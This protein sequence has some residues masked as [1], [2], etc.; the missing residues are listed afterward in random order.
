MNTDL[1][2]E[3][4]R[5]LD[6]F[7][8]RRRRLLLKRGACASA[9]AFLSAIALLA[10]VDYLTFLEDIARVALSLIAYTLVL[11]LAWLTSLRLM[12]RRPGRRE[13]ACL[14]ETC[15]PD[16]REYLL[17]AVEL[18]ESGEAVAWDSATYRQLLQEEVA[19]R[20]ASTDV[21]EQLPNS[22]IRWWPRLAAAATLLTVILLLLPGTHY[23]RLFAR[24]AIPG[25]NIS[26]L[27][28]T[29][30]Q[31]IQ[32]TPADTVVPQ[33]DV[34]S[35][36]A[37]LTGDEADHAHLESFV[38]GRAAGRIRMK[39]IAPRRFSAG[40]KIARKSVR[41]RVRAGDGMTRKY[42]IS[43]V[44][45]PRIT[46]F[47]KIITYPDY[48]GFPPERLV[49]SSGDLEVIEGAN[50]DLVL[51][52]DQRVGEAELRMTFGGRK[53]TIALKRMMLNKL[54]G[55][56]RVSASGTYRVHLVAAKTS[57]ENRF[58]PEYEIRTFP[59]LAPSVNITRP[60]RNLSAL[61]NQVLDMEIH[62]KD[63]LGLVEVFQMARVN[64]GH[65]RRLPVD[66]N[67]RGKEITIQHAW[68]M[69]AM[70]IR[71]GDQVTTKFMAKDLK[72][73]EGA[74]AL[75]TVT[76]V[77]PG[78]DKNRLEPLRRMKEIAETLADLHDAAVELRKTT[79]KAMAALRG[80]ETSSLKRRQ[81]VAR[82][83][84]ASEKVKEWTEAAGNQVKEAVKSAPGDE[85]A[86]EMTKFGR[87]LSK[88][89]R[90]GLEKP[91]EELELS[92]RTNSAKR[93]TQL[94]NQAS[95]AFKNTTSAS[96]KIARI[97]KQRLASE[98]ATVIVEDLKHL[99]AELDRTAAARKRAGDDSAAR[100]NLGRRQK[101]SLAHGGAV[102]KM[103]E[104]LSKMNCRGRQ[105]AVK[106]ARKE[107]N[108]TR[109]ASEKALLSAD[110]PAN[111]QYRRS[112]ESALAN[113]REVARELEKAAANGRTEL[114]RMIGD[115]SSDLDR[116]VSDI[117]KATEATRSQTPDSQET[118]ASVSAMQCHVKAR[119][120]KDRAD[121]EELR[122]DADGEF[123]NDITKAAEALE[124]LGAAQAGPDEQE[125]QQ[126]ELGRIS[127]AFKDLEIGHEFLEAAAMV[128]D[129]A[130][131]E[132]WA[133]PEPGADLS[134]ARD[135]ARADKALKSVVGRMKSAGIPREIQKQMEQVQE[136]SST[137]D[138]RKEMTGRG[139][140]A[141]DRVC[142][143]DQ[144]ADVSLE[145]DT[146]KNALAPRM[147]KAR[148][149][150]GRLRPAFAGRLRQ[151]AE[152]ARFLLDK[153]DSL[154]TGAREKS[155]RAVREGARGLLDEQE[156]LNEKLDDLRSALRRDANAQDLS[157]R[158]G[159]E[160]ARDADDAQALLR[161]P[162]PR[163]EDH[164]RQ[165]VGSLRKPVRLDAIK[166]ARKQQEE[167]AVIL[168]QLAVHFANLAADKPRETRAVLRR[169]ENR[170]G[171]G[172]KLGEQFEMA[173]RL[174]RMANE[175]PRAAIADLKHEMDGNREMR[176][177]LEKLRGKTGN[178]KT[179]CGAQPR[180]ALQT[181]RVGVGKWMARAL[182]ELEK[183]SPSGGD[184]GRNDVGGKNARDVERALRQAARAQARAMSASRVDNGVPGEALGGSARRA[185]RVGN[186]GRFG[187][188]SSLMRPRFARFGKNSDWGKLRSRK[189]VDL[190]DAR[191]EN[192]PEEYRPMVEAYFKAIAGKAR[193]GG[194]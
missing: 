125:E 69:L 65:W 49:E 178:G 127:K 64:S 86:F 163:A 100:S 53:E 32:P 60:D 140:G 102:E 87:A 45:R 186:S 146:V 157:T 170:L 78:F 2:P 95:R 46:S 36:I 10:L 152:E 48:T 80:N 187:F 68:D 12:W 51:R 52:A 72:G 56:V 162:P 155:G 82:I 75:L 164:L 76:I 24:A 194:D 70:D 141:Q 150:I 47:E 147:K 8:Q 183:G 19:E 116:L 191:G 105:Q 181:A 175:A 119:L 132:R 180:P 77:T 89:R 90:E 158:E 159:R 26:R 67:A 25:S 174:A 18:G 66:L 22:L 98:Q 30:I 34:V 5:K 156:R 16:L 129:L 57:F 110:T 160:R 173:E 93:A 169:A 171:L 112:V 122:P 20:V 55:S 113:M 121:L 118:T 39:Q 165:A 172:R 138:I 88:L 35:V 94:R 153:T 104:E 182:D 13:L 189:A 131:R 179:D 108:R 40:M 128:D 114:S 85:A 79:D 15:E 134:R 115:T 142:V 4:A 83:A 161:Q 130:A 21:A 38:D 9:T 190:I 109:E 91:G 6:L 103:L 74:S 54:S 154:L 44:P 37:E 120:L 84:R 101:A 59:D 63:D 117:R 43:A 62:A 145:L 92:E 193:N 7:G 137:L 81:G 28:R 167:I 33:G 99:L 97:F 23:W 123:V 144:L 3:V 133:G 61:P 41:Y 58:S 14:M 168:D 50:V 73:N 135:W 107:M 11:I 143:A 17:S 31:I 192:V 166:K 27:S 148:G 106:N 111:S 1:R 176:E 29:R 42:T 177:E 149:A 139:A 151:M 126:T 184:T 188:L 71:A 96:E 185:R 136:N 124:A